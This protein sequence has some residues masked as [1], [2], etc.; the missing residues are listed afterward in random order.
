MNSRSGIYKGK[1]KNGKKQCRSLIK[2]ILEIEKRSVKKGLILPFKIAPLL[3][4][5]PSLR[6]KIKKQVEGKEYPI[7]K[8]EVM[9]QIMG[10]FFKISQ[11]PSLLMCEGL[12]SKKLDCDLFCGIYLTIARELK[13]PLYGS[14]LPSHAFLIWTGVRPFLYFDTLSGYITDI[15]FRQFNKNIFCKP[16][17]DK[18]FMSTYY[19]T[20]GVRFSEIGKHE[21]AI[22]Y[23][24]E[25]LKCYPL[26]A[27]LYYHKAI[28]LAHLG[29]YRQALRWSK[30]AIRRD[31]SDW[32]AYFNM[33]VCL[34][35]SK[36]YEEAVSSYGCAAK[37]QPKDYRVYYY[38]A[39]ALLRMG[40]LDLAIKNYKK[41]LSLCPK[42]NNLREDYQ[43][44]LRYS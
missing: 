17:S 40:K 11:E 36:K 15:P 35:M 44:A 37:L 26:D 29:C 14:F 42:D 1:L 6:D 22:Y 31:S 7:T 3:Q 27:R 10:K 32:K 20:L 34:A 30:Q 28:S 43:T 4:F 12:K 38:R 18:E 2:N 19:N 33:G 25:A 23:F 5:L 39:D 24:D 16:L 9:H 8:L 41:A 21:D 13:L